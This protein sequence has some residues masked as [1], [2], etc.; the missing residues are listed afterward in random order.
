LT[1]PDFQKEPA[2]IVTR[3]VAAFVDMLVV[4]T[5]LFLV[6]AGF[7][8]V[9]FLA[10]PARFTMP[11][12]EWSVVVSVGGAVSVLY[13]ATAWTTTGR[14]LGAQVM[15]L[16][17]LDRRGQ[18][19]GWWRSTARALAYVVFPL[20]LAWSIVDSRRRSVQDLVVASSVVYDWI[21]RL[22]VTEEVRRA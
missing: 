19:L 11:S 13:L 4:I 20:G 18:R 16:R 17:V 14:T 8:A 15:G 9:A 3:T 7:A 1:R 5:A 2:G 12:P 21:P 6:W 10:R 22:P